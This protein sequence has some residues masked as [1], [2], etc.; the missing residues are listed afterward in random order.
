MPFVTVARIALL[1]AIVESDPYEKRNLFNEPES[2]AL[3]E[4]LLADFDRQ[5]KEVGFV[6]PDYADSTP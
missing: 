2:K 6:F 5:T 4:R 3:R 1:V